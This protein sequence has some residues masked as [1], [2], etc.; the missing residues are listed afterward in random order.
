MSQEALVRLLDRRYTLGTAEEYP[1][2]TSGI[3]KR[4]ASQMGRPVNWWSDLLFDLDL[5]GLRAVHLG[6]GQDQ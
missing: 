6:L 4:G 1:I 2:V 3:D 5:D